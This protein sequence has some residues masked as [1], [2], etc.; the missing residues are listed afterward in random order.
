MKPEQVDELA[1]GRYEEWLVDLPALKA[2]E[3]EDK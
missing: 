3:D 1:G 2:L